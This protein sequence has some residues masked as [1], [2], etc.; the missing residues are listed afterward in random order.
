[1]SSIALKEVNL[2]MKNNRYPRLARLLRIMGT[3][4]LT[5]LLFAGFLCYFSAAWYVSV[6]GRIGFDSVLYTLTQSLSGVQSGL[7]IQYLTGAAVPA[8]AWTAALT[9]LLFAPWK[10]IFKI[11][12]FQKIKLQLFPFKRVFSCCI[13]VLLSLLLV[14][15][16]AFNVQLVDYI[17]SNMHLSSLYENE[18]RDPEQIQITFP[19]EKRN[20]IYI[21]LESM[22][23]SYL[24]REQGGALEYNLIPELYQLAQDNVNFSNNTDVGG[25]REVSG[26]SW[27]VGSIVAQ[28]GGVPLKTPDGISDWQNGYGK[29][30]TFLPGL[31]S[32]NSMLRDNGYYQALMVGSDANFGG[33]KTYFATHGVDEIY[34]IYAARADGIIPRDYFVWWGMED[35]YLFEYAKQEIT[36][37]AAMDQPFNFTMLTVDTHHVGGY[38]CEYC[39][40][41]YEENYENVI[42]CSSRQ[43]YEFVQWLMQQDFYENTTVIITGDHCSMDK[44]YFTRNVDENY[45]R[46]VYNC[47]LNAAAE[48]GRTEN[49]QFS[50]LDMFPTTL[51]ALGCQI[52]GDRLGL[53]TNLF[54]DQPTLMERV[55][56]ANLCSELAN[57]T[58]FY[59]SKFYAKEK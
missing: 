9:L 50:A 29:D 54:S 14:V 21:I 2:F 35:K 12:L 4:V 31:T 48:P 20:L 17:I 38:R 40:S 52:E 55:G 30:G 6:Y 11:I 39:D 5:L 46:H 18:Y 7:I 49:R 25:F 57:R 28:T 47:F 10:K 1:M 36:Q 42:S 58:E 15:H 37:I 23:T 19:E 34:D 3:A 41:T 32:L 24:S 33:R 43:V 8:L 22:E 16:A 13:C 53:G 26:A 44:G 27:T 45:T 51:A 59:A 56:Y